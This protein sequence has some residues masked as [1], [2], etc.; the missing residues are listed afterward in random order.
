MTAVIPRL[1]SGI[2]PHPFGVQALH[3][4][5]VTVESS[6]SEPGPDYGSWTKVRLVAELR[7]RGL[8]QDG[9]KSSLVARIIENDSKNSPASP[10]GAA[11]P[12][13][14]GRAELHEEV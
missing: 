9:T 6:G 5:R 7:R 11:S 14:E 1:N 3:P 10:V 12:L 4:V 13:A 2:G 8:R